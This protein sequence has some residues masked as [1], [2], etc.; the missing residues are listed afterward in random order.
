MFQKRLAFL[1][2][3][4]FRAESSVFAGGRETPFRFEANPLRAMETAVPE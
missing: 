3:A 1:A 4:P 2:F